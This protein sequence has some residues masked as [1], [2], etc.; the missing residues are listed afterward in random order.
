MVRYLYHLN[1]GVNQ[2]EGMI[3]MAATLLT[4][5]DLATELDTD[6]RTVRKFLRSITPKDAQPGKG[7]RWSIEKKSLRSLRKQYADWDAART[8]AEVPDE[9]PAED[10]PTED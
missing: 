7:S 8:P 2:I 6:S 1:E 3:I 4:P 10:A 9:T 5:A